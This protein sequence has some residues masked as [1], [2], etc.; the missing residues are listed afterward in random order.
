MIDYHVDASRRLVTSRASG[1][2][3]LVDLAHHLQRIL[4]D[5]KFSFSF[6]GL[7]VVG[8]RRSI[9]P[10]ELVGL[11][12]PLV[13]AWSTQ[14]VGVRWAFVLPDAASKTVVESILHELRLTGI[15]SRC[16]VSE[17]AAL[18]WLDSAP[19]P[20]SSVSGTPFQSFRSD[21]PNVL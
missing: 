8:D 11:M 15:T 2:V 9:P 17:G 6:N 12:K 19:P 5:P 16:F 18:A 10:P 14:R 20:N 1:P 21:S 4:R 3:S 7:I 13:K